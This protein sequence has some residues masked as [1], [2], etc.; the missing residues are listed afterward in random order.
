MDDA[1]LSIIISI[2]SS[3]ARPLR[4]TL[5]NHKRKRADAYAGRHLRALT[6]TCTR[7]KAHIQIR[8]REP[9]EAKWPCP[10]RHNSRRLA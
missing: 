5:T 3:A 6:H 7:T 4:G 10:T 9:T 8:T 1:V 2:L